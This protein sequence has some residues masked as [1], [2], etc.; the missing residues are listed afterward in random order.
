MS[1]PT[2]GPWH[3]THARLR[4]AAHLLP[5]IATAAWVVTLA[6]PVLDSGDAAGPR[7]VVTSLGAQPFDLTETHPAFLLAW[8]GVLGCAASVW[9]LRS[10]R[11]WS[12]ATMLVAPMLGALLLTTLTDPP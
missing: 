2:S 7:I 10:L 11:W 4:R 1:S 5:L 6:L 9:L 12:V 3:S 8:I